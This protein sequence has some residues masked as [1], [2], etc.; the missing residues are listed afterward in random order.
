[1]GIQVVLL[2]WKPS[3]Q[4]SLVL[5]LG[6]AVAYVRRTD[7]D[8]RTGDRLTDAPGSDSCDLSSHLSPVSK[9]PRPFPAENLRLAARPPMQHREQTLSR[10]QES[11]ETWYDVEEL[12]CHSNLRLKGKI[13]RYAP[14]QVW[15]TAL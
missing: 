12:S 7:P 9:I 4:Y 3:W 6:A 8:R 13:V 5:L 2:A 15:T 1:M 11:P 10:V 14:N